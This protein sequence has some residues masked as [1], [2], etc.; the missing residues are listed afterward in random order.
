MSGGRATSGTAL[1][2][3][4]TRGIGRAIALRL[5][6]DGYKVALNYATDTAA[7]ERTLAELRALHPAAIALPADVGAPADSEGRPP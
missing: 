1:V 4:S 3:G 5:A 6:R 2:T 7:A